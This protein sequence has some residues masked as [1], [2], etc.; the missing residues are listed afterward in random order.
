MKKSFVTVLSL[1]VLT[2]GALAQ[3]P[4]PAPAPERAPQ[5]ENRERMQRGAMGGD[6]GARGGER[7]MAGGGMEMMAGGGMERIMAA[8]AQNPELAA[9]LNMTPEQQDTIKK[10]TLDQRTKMVDLQGVLQKAA[11][12]QAELLMA[13]PLDETAL[14]AAVEETSKARAEM[15]KAMI[16]NLIEIRKVLTEEQRKQLRDMVT[17]MRQNPPM[18]QPGEG[19]GPGRVNRGEGRGEAPAPA[20]APTREAAPAPAPAAPVPAI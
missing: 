15:A 13:E 10:M 2:V 4:S 18:R 5:P 11:L 7:R 14:M 12:K 16:L 17:Q 3:A 9:K 6:R 8:L 1:T 19:R 20:P